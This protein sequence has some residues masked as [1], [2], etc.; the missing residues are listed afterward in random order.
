MINDERKK[1]TIAVLCFC[2]AVLLT[3]VFAVPVHPQAA[4]KKTWIL[5]SGIQ[6]S[7]RLD[8]DGDGKKEKVELKTSMDEEQA[9]FSTVSFYVDG[10]E[11]LSFSDTQMTMV[12]AD[13]V[14]MNDSAVFL[15]VCTTTDNDCVVT[16]CIYTYDP[17]KKKL[18]EAAKLLED[19]CGVI[20]A[21]AELDSVDS[22]EFSIAY[23]MQFDEIGRVKWNSSY[24][25]ENGKLKLKSNTM[26]AKSSMGDMVLNEDGY[27]S[28]FQKNQFQAMRRIRLY[29]NTA[30]KSV[31]YT[32]AKGDILKLTKMKYAGK[33]LFV[34]FS[35]DGKKGWMKLGQSGLEDPSSLFYGVAPRLAG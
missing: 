31:S 27:N 4:V 14:Q 1:I 2:A 22:T 33:S 19:L 12:R 26:K 16:D 7:C 34:Q 8:L 3:G 28:R 29:D 5:V 11:A 15:R 23:T 9:Y 17:A 20:H 6:T 32:A 35:K 21:Q 24:T 30:L 13:Y 25:L 18:V 10:S